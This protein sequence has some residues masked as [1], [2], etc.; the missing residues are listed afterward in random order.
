M[1]NSVVLKQLSEIEYLDKN[2]SINE[3][4]SLNVMNEK[5]ADYENGYLNDNMSILMKY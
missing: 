1:S 2:G 4:M 3:N 5:P